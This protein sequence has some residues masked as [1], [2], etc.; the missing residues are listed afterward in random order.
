MKTD[1]SNGALLGA[2]AVMSWV[3]SPAVAQDVS[4]TKPEGNQAN[5]SFGSDEIVVTA[6]R[7]EQKLSDVGMSI[8]AVGAETLRNRNVVSADELSKL[9]PGLSV[10]DSGY[11]TP[12][13][14]LRG[15]GINEPSLG[16]NSSVAIYVDEVPLVYPATTQGAALDLQR[17]EVLKGPQ[18]TLYGQNSTGGAINYIANKPTSEFQG[19]LTGTFGRFN[20]GLLEGFLSGP[21]TPTLKARVAARGEFGDGWQKSITRDD[22]LGKIRRFTG[23]AILE[24]EPSD[25]LKVSFNANGWTD[26]SDTI[27]S[28]FVR[29]FPSNPALADPDVINAPVAHQN[30]RAADWAPDEEFER[31]DKFWQASMRTEWRAADRL[32]LTSITSYAHMKRNQWTD[33]GGVAAAAVMKIRQ[34]GK[35]RSFAQELRAA[36]DLEG[37]NWVVGGNFSRDRTA[38]LIAQ[39]NP[40]SS[41]V[42]NLFGFPVDGAANNSSQKIRNLAIFTNL[43]IKISDKFSLNGGIRYSEETRKFKGCT[44]INS[45]SSSNGWTAAVNYFRGLNGLASI[46]LIGAG[47]CLSSYFSS[48]GLARDTG[49]AQL[50]TPGFANQTLKEHNIPWNVGLNYKPGNDSLIYARVSRGFKSGN[51]SNLGALQAEVYSPLVQE[52]LT[53][54][55][56]GGRARF[57]RLLT[58]E[59]ALFQYDYDNKQLRARINVGPPI[60][61]INAQDTIPKSRIRGI[62]GMLGLR[63]ADGLLLQVQVTYLDSKIREYIGYTVDGVLQDQ[64]GSRFNFTPKYSVNL[65]LQYNRPISDTLEAFTGINV[66]YRSATSA[67]FNPPG[68]PNL[69]DFRID[70]HTLVDGQIGVQDS[71]GKWRAFVWGKNIFNKFYTTNAVRVS[72][73]FVRYA[74]QPATYGI[75]A[76]YNF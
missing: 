10:S 62:E 27:A 5:A 22:T 73:V 53:A 9:V 17:I 3:C 59:G 25:A 30:I 16:S 13:Y 69:D 12:I 44:V 46:P 58:V 29:A 45:D 43:D 34:A 57:G 33:V 11:S 18:G 61:N 35:I 52:K 40:D 41:Q 64:S 14:T 20:R 68:Y 37:I 55:E 23:R 4:G 60:G 28:Q 15:V 8:T 51:F 6:Q 1:I 72:D 47:E 66:A 50:L 36:I 65:D 54:Y 56:L 42:R 48:A 70:S 71:R 67:V 31:D 76:S 7:R 32:V 26:R 74:G 24:W 19:G 49:G 39:F 2:V 21:L 75:T 38:D 63:P